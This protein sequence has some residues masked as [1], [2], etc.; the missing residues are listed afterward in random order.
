VNVVQPTARGERLHD[1]DR[2]LTVA[3]YVAAGRRAERELAPALELPLYFDFPAAFRSLERIAGPYDGHCGIRGILGLL[4]GG[5]YALCGIGGQVPELV[6]GRA[7]ETPLAGVWSSHP[8]LRSI[9]EGLP[10]R[11]GGVCGECLLRRACL[12]ACVAQNYYRSRD[13]FAPNWFCEQA[14]SAGLFPASR[15]R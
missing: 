7:G 10:D 4:A 9:R 11:L 8:V 5:E 2:A 3:E 14:D 6:F 15:R 12:G 1:D 13:L